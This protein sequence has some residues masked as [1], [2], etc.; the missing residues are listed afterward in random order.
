MR[1]ALAAAI[2]VGLSSPACGRIGFDSLEWRDDGA[3][4]RSTDA[5]AGGSMDASLPPPGDGGTPNGSTGGGGASGGAVTAADASLDGATDGAGPAREGGAD[6]D[7][8]CTGS[9][10][11]V[12]EQRMSAAFPSNMHDWQAAGGGLCSGA[13]CDGADFVCDVGKTCGMHAVA[14]SEPNSGVCRSGATCRVHSEGDGFDFVNPFVCEAGSTCYISAYNGQLRGPVVCAAGATCSFNANLGYIEGV[15]CKA[16]SECFFDCHNGQCRGVIIETNVRALFDCELASCRI[17]CP[18]GAT[19]LADCT[20]NGALDCPT[21]AA[22]ADCACFGGTGT[23]AGL[24]SGAAD[25][26]CASQGAQR[27]LTDCWGF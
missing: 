17:T 18:A 4:G 1:A 25:P 5:S 15:T 20:G 26:V 3:G 21:C 14:G 11:A 12:F 24:C 8:P 27:L 9:G 2:V 13:S 22:G 6:A 19:C 23:C 16:G 10:V 7:A